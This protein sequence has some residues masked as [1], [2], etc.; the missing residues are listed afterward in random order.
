MPPRRRK[1]PEPAPEP[2][3]PAEN[4]ASASDH[5]DDD[6]NNDGIDPRSDVEDDNESSHLNLRF[7]N[8]TFTTY[9]ASPLYVNPNLDAGKQHQKKQAP[10]SS[11]SSPSSIL[12]TPKALETLS[13]RLRD[14]LVGD[15]VRGVQVGLGGPEGDVAALGRTGALLRVEWRW[16]GVDSLLGYDG[17]RRAREGSEE[18]GGVDNDED[19]D[20]K[21]VMSARALCLSLE[22]ENATFGAFLLPDLGGSEEGEGDEEGTKPSWTWQPPAA[23]PD[24]GS[25]SSSFIHLPLLL[26]RMPAALKSVLIDFLSIMFDCRISPLHLGTRTLVRSWETW[27]ASASGTPVKDAALTLGFHVPGE[28]PPADGDEDEKTAGQELRLGLK[29]IDVIVPAGQVQRFVRA[30]RGIISSSDPSKK[31]RGL[32]PDDRNGDDEKRQRRRMLAGGRD[33]EGW[34]WR[35]E[36][37]TTTTTTDDDLKKNSKGKGKGKGKAGGEREEE[38]GG[39]D[40]TFDQPFSEALAAYL[41]AH[42][43]LDL[44]HPGVRVLRVACDGFALSSGG[45]VKV[46]ASA[47]DG[48]G[49]VSWTF[50]RDLVGC[51]K[52]RRRRR[53][54]KGNWGGAGAG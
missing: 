43:A 49:A 42:L 29:S 10:S 33:E 6:H 35:R 44:F 22:Y 28:P 39:D 38:E 4:P 31:K 5:E 13:K 30:G 19:G 45:R 40:N 34:G 24:S 47:A 20:R 12:L 7:Y 3:R 53:I 52:G 11:S 25:H 27:L 50:M 1:R 48:A 16:R 21:P 14:T 54:I 8:T 26:L 36:D 17:W 2:D 9:R 32:A 15:V 37:P 46:F 23:G 18:L 51:A 41:D